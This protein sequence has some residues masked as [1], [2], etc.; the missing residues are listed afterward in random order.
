[1]IVRPMTPQLRLAE[2][3]F[4]NGISPIGMSAPILLPRA[5]FIDFRTNLDRR[6]C[7]GI[8]E[9]RAGQAAHSDLDLDERAPGMK[10]FEGDL[11][12]LDNSAV[13]G[14][15]HRGETQCSPLSLRFTPV[16]AGISDDVS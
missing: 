9:G 11:A 6:A 14:I 2:P 1:M 13:N 10:R 16:S 4:G 7:H 8:A 12:G 3:P 5:W 15:R